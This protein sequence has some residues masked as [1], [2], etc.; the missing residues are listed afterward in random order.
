MNTKHVYGVTHKGIHTDTSDT[1]LG[2]KQYATRNGY[3]IVSIRYNCGYNVEVIA[4]KE[5]GRWVN[6][7]T[8]Q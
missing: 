7:Q 5:G 6:K 4:I 1:L 8:I 2:A 3:S